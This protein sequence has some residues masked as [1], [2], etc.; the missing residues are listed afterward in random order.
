[1]NGIRCPDNE[2]AGRAEHR[3]W[4]EF[5]TLSVPCSQYVLLEKA[6][7]VRLSPSMPPQIRAWPGFSITKL[8]RNVSSRTNGEKSSSAVRDDDPASGDGEHEHGDQQ[9]HRCYRGQAMQNK[10]TQQGPW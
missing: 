10:R 4:Q 5:C 9:R 8:P 3:K 7:A 6:C 2:T 1:M